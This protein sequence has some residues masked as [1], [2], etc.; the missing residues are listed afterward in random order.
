MKHG[1][2]AEER[3]VA[4]SNGSA[5]SSTFQLAGS[6]SFLTSPD[7]PSARREAAV[8]MT[9]PNVHFCMI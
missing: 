7:L 2:Q 6:G 8:A 9:S 4:Y 1:S 5:G 3:V